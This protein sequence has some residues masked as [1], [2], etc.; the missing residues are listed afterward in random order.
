M[1]ICT[2]HAGAHAVADRAPTRARL[3]CAAQRGH[4]AGGAESEAGVAGRRV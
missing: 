3:G 4:V 2:A 1:V